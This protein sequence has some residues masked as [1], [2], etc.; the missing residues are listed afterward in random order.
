MAGGAASS[1]S[2]FADS[3]APF[4]LPHRS[5][6]APA[7]IATLRGCDSAATACRPASSIVTV[8]VPESCDTVPAG[9]V[10]EPSVTEM[11]SAETGRD[12]SERDTVSTPE[13]VA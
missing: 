4:E 5:W 9:T 3:A 12:A 8:M 6:S 7:E 13:D 11:C 10:A 2:M 1:Y